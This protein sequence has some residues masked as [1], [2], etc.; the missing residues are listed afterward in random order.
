[1]FNS[2]IKNKNACRISLSTGISFYL[3]LSL[4]II[5]LVSVRA[6]SAL[7]GRQ[8]SIKHL[9]TPSITLCKC[10]S[11]LNS[12][13][14]KSWYIIHALNLSSGYSDLSSG[15]T[16]CMSICSIEFLISLCLKI[17]C[18]S[19]PTAAIKASFILQSLPV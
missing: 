11:S 17:E 8:L 5:N 7:T 3:V 16:C 18:S 9:Y 14:T 12:K 2:C 15:R 13:C 19:A 10:F 4:S 6:A 1:V